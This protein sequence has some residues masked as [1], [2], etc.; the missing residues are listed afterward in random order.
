VK[1]AVGRSG[2]I[3][4]LVQKLL[5]TGDKR[6]IGVSADAV[7]SSGRNLM[8]LG[9]GGLRL[10]SLYGLLGCGEYRLIE[11]SLDLVATAVSVS[12]V[13]AARAKH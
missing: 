11:L 12:P 8:G 9:I 6:P 2:I 3:A 7:H 13:F 1:L 5:R 4:E 10:P